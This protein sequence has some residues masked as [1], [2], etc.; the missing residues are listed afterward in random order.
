[1]TGAEEINKSHASVDTGQN[2]MGSTISWSFDI[3]NQALSERIRTKDY[4]PGP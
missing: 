2:A 4:E 1:M 3:K